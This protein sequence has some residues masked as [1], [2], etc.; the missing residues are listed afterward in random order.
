[1]NLEILFIITARGGSKGVPRKNLQKI[2]GLSLI[3][4][5]A[6]SAHKSKYCTRLIISTEDAEIQ[7]EAKKLNIEV[8]FTRPAALA[9]D[10]ASSDSVIAHAVKY[11]QEEEG[12]RYDAIMMLE[13]A[14]P[15]GRAADYDAAVEKLVEKKASLVVGMRETDVNSIFLGPLGADQKADRIVEKF[16]DRKDNRRQALEPEFT[17]NGALYL[18]D[19]NA[20]VRT[21]RIYSD[22]ATTYGHVMDRN[23]SIEI[24]KPIDL[25]LAEFMVEKNF[26]SMKEWQ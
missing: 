15:F 18:M 2:A 23:Y 17:M 3:G 21:G 5:K 14:S 11:V 6:N 13:P 19:W 24:D 9:S 20:F 8:P 7:E 4:F 26:V 1:M 25:A 22:P 10:T 12:R 16:F